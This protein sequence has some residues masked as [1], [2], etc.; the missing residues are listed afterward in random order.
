MADKFFTD[1]VVVYSDKELD[2]YLESI[3]AECDMLL[4]DRLKGVLSVRNLIEV[5][6]DFE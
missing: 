5:R 3:I 2:D 1:L 6:N 4:G